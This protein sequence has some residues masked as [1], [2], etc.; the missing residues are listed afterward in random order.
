MRGA[1]AITMIVVGAGLMFL[2]V[3]GRFPT[4]TGATFGNGPIHPGG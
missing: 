4:N 2:I 3:R 1:L